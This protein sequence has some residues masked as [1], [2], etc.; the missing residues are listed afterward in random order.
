ML[1]PKVVRAD[2]VVAQ[3]GTGQFTTIGAAIAAAPQQILERHVIYVKSGLY[4]EIL[5]V[6]NT[7]WNLTRI[8]DGMGATIIT[9]NR[10]VVD[11]YAMAETATVG[12]F[13]LWNCFTNEC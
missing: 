11:H 7:T 9:G 3:D 12:M 1:Q 8:G 10:S 6:S 2:A 4:D 13:L 5:R